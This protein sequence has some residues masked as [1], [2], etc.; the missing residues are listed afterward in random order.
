LGARGG[1]FFGGSAFLVGGA[2]VLPLEDIVRVA[3]RP[4]VETRLKSVGKFIVVLLR[5][6]L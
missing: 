5:V 2:P 1:A 3:N 6:K 4:D